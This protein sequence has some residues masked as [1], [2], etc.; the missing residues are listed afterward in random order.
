[1]KTGMKLSEGIKIMARILVLA[2]A[3]EL[4]ATE[5]ARY[6]LDAGIVASREKTSLPGIVSR[7]LFGILE[8]RPGKIFTPN[9]DGWD[10]YFEIRYSNP[11][12]SIVNGKIFS[13]SGAFVA[14]MKKDLFNETLIWDGADSNGY[15]AHSGIYIYQI[16]VRGGETLIL[17]GAIILA[18]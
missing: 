5:K 18:R 14:G 16:D 2:A 1:M 8:I 11:A 17:N 7:D 6:R 12:D 9:G 13:I 15:T 10:D 4:L 3:V